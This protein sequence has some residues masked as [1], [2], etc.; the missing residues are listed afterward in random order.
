MEVNQERQG[1]VLG[2]TTYDLVNTAA[3]LA[4]MADY[5]IALAETSDGLTESEKSDLEK[6]A[7]HFDARRSEVLSQI[8]IEV[9]AR[10]HDY[11]F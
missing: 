9:R 8:P 2:P 5:R 4:E 6:L 1:N 11:D 7:A 10:L 3:D